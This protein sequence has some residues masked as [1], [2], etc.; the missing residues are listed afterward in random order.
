MS[1]SPH[2]LPASIARR[3]KG[4]SWLVFTTEECT[5][6]LDST[7]STPSEQKPAGVRDWVAAVGGW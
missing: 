7:L 2:F 5:S 1:H 6:V 3:L 4:V